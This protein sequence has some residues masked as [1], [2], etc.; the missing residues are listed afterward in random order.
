MRTATVNGYEL[1]RRREDNELTLNDLAALC[2]VELGKTVHKST[3]AR[4]ER[5]QRQPSSRLFGTIC[6]ALN[7]AK[8]DLIMPSHANS[9]APVTAGAA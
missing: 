9:S 2:A 8:S 7:C 4:I 3:L 6:R 1:R 5:G